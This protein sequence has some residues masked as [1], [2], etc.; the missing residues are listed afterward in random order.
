MGGGGSKGGADKEADRLV[1]GTKNGSPFDAEYTKGAKLGEGAYAEVFLGV[2]TDHVSPTQRP[3]IASPRRESVMPCQP[4]QR[5]AVKCIDKQ[6][7]I[8]EGETDMLMSEVKIMWSCCDHPNIIQLH[9]VFESKEMLYLVLECMTGGE[10]FERLARDFEDGFTEK[11]ARSFVRKVASAL[12]HLHH[13]QCIHRDI[14]P[15]NLLLPS[16]DNDGNVKL[17]DF[18]LAVMGITH[19]E[20]MDPSTITGT[21]DYMAPEMLLRE[22][23]GRPIDCWALGVITYIILC[24]FPPFYPDGDDMAPMFENIKRGK[25]RFL[26]PYWDKVSEGAKD[27]VLKLLVTD[28][29][30]RLTA[31][32]VLA[33]K[34]VV[35][36]VKDSNVNLSSIG[37][38]D[39]MK[40]FNAR[41]KLKRAMLKV[42]AASRFRI[43][44][45]ASKRDSGSSGGGGGAGGSSA[46][47]DHNI[48][49][50]GTSVEESDAPES[51]RSDATNEQKIDEAAAAQ[52]PDFKRQN[53]GHHQA[54]L[55]ALDRADSDAATSDAGTPRRPDFTRTNT[56]TPR[57][58]LDAIAAAGG[59]DA[60]EG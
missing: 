25:F 31:E 39:N 32:Q 28:P 53:T 27:L 4:G 58:A 50:V 60:V 51:A 29:T 34:W 47:A 55:D 16:E 15:E 2:A 26:E 52:R 11:I 23:Y 12:H 35:G 45:R 30:K 6:K 48:D 3:D 22:H 54:T 46:G 33:H 18:G 10:M 37:W 56:G 49:N 9:D 57:E 41:V 59:P 36:S 17:A 1:P 42:R 19:D 38:A 7:L 8:E 43:L 24:G 40:R 13:L 44:M 21:P 20:A 5:V 14:K